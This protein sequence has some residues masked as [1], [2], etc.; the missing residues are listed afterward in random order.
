MRQTRV[1]SGQRRL[2]HLMQEIRYG[3]IE[4][5][6]V[7]GGQPIFETEP[8]VVWDIK[9]G[10]HRAQTKIYPDQELKA[11]VLE[12]LSNLERLGDG[13]VRRLEVQNGLP[14]RIQIERRAGA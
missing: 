2:I 14:F 8:V 7:S 9:I 1:S 11:Q 10:A 5:L 6:V 3:L 4:G 12:L 13:K